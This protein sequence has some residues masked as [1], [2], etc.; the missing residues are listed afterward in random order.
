MARAGL[1]ALLATNN[2]GVGPPASRAAQPGLHAAASSCCQVPQA[3]AYSPRCRVSRACHGRQLPVIAVIAAANARRQCGRSLLLGWPPCPWEAE[4]VPGRP[5]SDIIRMSGC[6]PPNV[7][8]NAWLRHRL[9]L[10]SHRGPR[11]EL[12]LQPRPARHLRYCCLHRQCLAGVPHDLAPVQPE[13]SRSLWM[14]CK[15]RTNSQA[16]PRCLGLQP[17]APARS[18]P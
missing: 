1:W 3:S 12:R 7:P 9:H 10:T 14:Q 2:P 4:R 13:L 8:S 18:T 16:P 11:L 17:S 6:Y 15:R 5:P